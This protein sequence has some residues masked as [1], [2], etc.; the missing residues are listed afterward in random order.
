L[1]SPGMMWALC[2]LLERSLSKTLLR[3]KRL[4]QT[5]QWPWSSRNSHWQKSSSMLKQSWANLWKSSI[6][7]SWTFGLSS[8]LL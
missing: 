2:Q 5:S 6:K 7:P 3:R 8:I 1:P 4:I